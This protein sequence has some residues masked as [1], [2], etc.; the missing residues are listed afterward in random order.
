MARGEIILRQW[1][2]L[3]TLQTR[4]AGIPL[5]QL[6]DEFEV[7]DRTIQRDFEVLQELGFPVEYEED[8]Y[9]KR[10]WRMPH[11]FFK[12]GP[13]VLGLTEA[14]SLHLAENLFSPLAGTHFADGLRTTL[15]KVRSLIPARALEYFRELDRTIYVRR[16]GVTD[17]SAH[18]ETIR[19]LLDAAHVRHSVEVTYH[20]LW[21]ADEYTTLFDPYGLVY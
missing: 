5:K 4:G 7:S 19:V 3:K 9:G 11:D 20:A 15:N 12:T 16:S 17:Y 18:A 2:L 21:R 6:A 10:Y 8:E 1:N 13:L 14:V